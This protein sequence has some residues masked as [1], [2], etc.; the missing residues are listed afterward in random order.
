MD[1]IGL[2]AIGICLHVFSPSGKKM[3]I[4]SLKITDSQA[5]QGCHGFTLI[6]VLI[7]MAIFAIGFLAIAGLQ[8]GSINSNA[9]ARMQSEA[10]TAAVDAMERLMSLPYEHPDLDEASGIQQRQV[11]PYTVNWQITEEAPI[12][13]CKTISVWVSTDKPNAKQVRI[14]LIRGPEW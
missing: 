8:I 13:W 12:S 10:T 6:E 11:G 2:E 4:T 7:A 3:N 9:A 14:S 1:L 5:A